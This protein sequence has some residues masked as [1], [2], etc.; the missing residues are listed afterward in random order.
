MALTTA[1]WI[2][3][4]QTYPSDTTIRFLDRLILFDAPDGTEAKPLFRWVEPGE[5][6]IVG[7]RVRK[8]GYPDTGTVA[9]IFSRAA[10]VLKVMALAHGHVIVQWDTTGQSI[11]RAEDLGRAL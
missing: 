9:S 6:L 3:T 10:S 11:E 8:F 2:R 7:S 4:L 5:D 1:D